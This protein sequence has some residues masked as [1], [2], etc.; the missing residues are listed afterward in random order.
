MSGIWMPDPILS[1]KHQKFVEMDDVDR[2][3]RIAG[4]AGELV[5]LICTDL[6]LRIRGVNFSAQYVRLAHNR[7]DGSVTIVGFINGD[8]ADVPG[9]DRDG[10]I[11]RLQVEFAHVLRLAVFAAEPSFEST[12]SPDVDM[13]TFDVVA[14]IVGSL[15]AAIARDYRAG[16]K[17]LKQVAVDH[18]VSL[19]VV[20][21]ALAAARLGGPRA[22]REA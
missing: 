20:H 2:T 8:G 11:E 15:Y 3:W 21:K 6:A 14:W 4:I 12:E 16:G 18:R 7:A 13:L 19:S 10:L 9:F 22:P 5:R 1:E 17:T